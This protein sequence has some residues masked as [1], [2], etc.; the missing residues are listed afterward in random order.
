MPERYW[1]VH[2]NGGRQL[3]DPQ[4]FDLERL[5][6]QARRLGGRLEI[7][8][9]DEHRSS[10][11]LGSS[12]DRFEPPLS[13][14]GPMFRG[15]L[16]AIH[17]CETPF[18]IDMNPRPTVRVLG[19]YYKRRRLVRVYTHDRQTGRRPL[20]ELFDT[21]LH[22]VA[23]HIEYTEPHSFHAPACGR[24]PGRMHSRL[25]WRILGELKGR[26]N[27]HQRGGSPVPPRPG[28]RGE[29]KHP[30]TPRRSPAP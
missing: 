3:I 15:R 24:V 10:A 23:H 5:A 9:R 29:K 16:D 19:G 18:A 11:V 1:L 30:F 17:A 4:Q 27:D 28:G 20:E 12:P 2:P 8:G 13:A 25:F 14:L 21:F 26:W 7:E 6:E 22:E